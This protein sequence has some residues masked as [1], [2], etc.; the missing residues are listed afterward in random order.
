MAWQAQ[1]YRHRTLNNNNEQRVAVARLDETGLSAPKHLFEQVSRTDKLLLRP[2][3]AFDGSGR[4]WLTARESIRRTAGW[5]PMAWCYSGDRWSES[6]VLLEEPGRWRPISMALTPNGLIA[7]CQ[8]DNIPQGRAHQGIHPD[9]LSGVATN[10][11]LE[12]DAPPARQLEVEPLKMPPT[13]FSLADKIALCCAEFPRQTMR[14]SGKTLQLFWGNLHEHT[15]LSACARSMNPPGHDL[16]ANVRDIERLDFCALTDHDFDFDFPLW[17][18]NGEQTRNNNDPGRFVTFLG[19]EW[20]SSKNPPAV[21]GNPNRYGHHNLIFL[22]PFHDR[23]YDSYDGDISPADLW[24]QLN[25]VEFVCIPHELADWKGKGKGNP[26]TDWTY[27]DE[28]LQPLAEIF[29]ARQSYEYLGC[30]R[31][32]PE[33]APFKG[34]Y[35]QDAWAKGIVIGTIASSD[36]GG[37][38]GKAGVWAEKLTRESLFE[39]MRARH[40]FGTSGSKMSLFFGTDTAMMGD[41]LK[42]PG[43]PITFQ[44]R[45]LA[46]HDIREL[47]IFRNNQIVRRVE[48]N[49]KQV[50]LKWTDGEPPNVTLWYYARIHTA[51]NELAWSSPI[52]FTV[53]SK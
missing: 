12:Q 33:G 21:P 44:V 27:T 29:Q 22:R 24:Q 25:G 39:A 31:Q 45:A 30:P 8:F 48:P 36:H 38:N 19:E 47:V 37:G 42:H 17:D 43:K 34:Y 13:D 3:I 51:D 16:F 46:F 20:T 15:D 26:P 32:S 6:Q 1:S 40:T 5:R 49:Q 41:K 28:K 14:H 52:W 2:Q 18:Y 7:A 10:P 23:F 11:D 4:L 9:L 35:L 50:D 53:S